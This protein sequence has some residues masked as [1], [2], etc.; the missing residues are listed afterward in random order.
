LK[1]VETR[2]VGAEEGEEGGGAKE[3]AGV[4]EEGVGGTKA[5]FEFEERTT[6]W[7]VE[8]TCDFNIVAML[9]PNSI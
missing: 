1:T 2:K 6:L 8:V 7:R 4:S 5:E 3:A 9:S